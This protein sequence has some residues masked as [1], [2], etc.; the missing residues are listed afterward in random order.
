MKKYSLL[1]I[2]LFTYAIGFTHQNISKPI[3]IPF[4][5]TPNGHIMIKATVNGVEGNFV[6]D[7]GAGLNMVTKKFADKVGNLEPT[8]HFH[9]GHRATGEAL[10]TDLWIANTLAINDFMVASSIFSVFDVDFPLDGLI[11]LTPFIDQPIT[12]DF[13]NKKL[14]IESKKSFKRIVSNEEFEMPLLIAN[15]KDIVIDIA[16]TV[17]LNDTLLLN[18][19]LDS[20]AGFDVYRFSSRY[21]K[22]L[23]ID[24]NTVKSIYKPSDFKPEEGNTYYTTT[25]SKMTDINQNTSVNDFKV[26]FIDG[27]IYEGITS[28]NWIGKK[29]TIDIQNKRLCVKQ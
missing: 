4:T 23:N 28:I 10:E 16:T 24:K 27:L 18:V 14:V 5:L 17:K 22:T 1:I 13:E 6:F 7:T 29:M 20:G 25:L 8:N 26:T 15:D 19:N 9:T 11:S 3:E 21:M 12:I 2:L